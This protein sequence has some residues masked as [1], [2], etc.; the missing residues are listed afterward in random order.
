MDSEQADIIAKRDEVK[1][2]LADTEAKAA[3]YEAALQASAAHFQ[4]LHDVNMSYNNHVRVLAA[5]HVLG[6]WASHP[7]AVGLG[8]LG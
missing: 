6:T 3:E 2:T 5:W 1:A 7:V 8:D 4:H